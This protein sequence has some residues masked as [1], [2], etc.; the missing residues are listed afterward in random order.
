MFITVIVVLINNVFYTT[1]YA[2]IILELIALVAASIFYWLLIKGH[3]VRR[4]SSMLVIFLFVLIDIGTLTGS[5]LLVGNVVIYLLIVIVMNYLIPLRKKNLFGMLAFLNL[6]FLAILEY[7]LRPEITFDSYDS[8][9]IDKNILV[10]LGFGICYYLTGHMREKYEEERT[11]SLKQN[12]ELLEKNRKI[13]TQ[14]IEQRNLTAIIAHDLR[15][16]LNNIIGLSSILKESNTLSQKEEELVDR[17]TSI[18]DTGRELISEIVDMSNFEE[19][20]Y[21]LKL[22]P[23]KINQFVENQVNAYEGQLKEKNL[24]IDLKFGPKD[25]VVST[26]VHLLERIL[27]NLLSNAIKFSPEH[28]KI[29]IKIEVTSERFIVSVKDEGPGFTDVDKTLLYRKFQKLSARP[30]GD[31][32]STGLGLAIVK[33][34][35]ELLSGKIKLISEKGKGAE[36]VLE[37]PLAQTI[38]ISNQS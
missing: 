27:D 9:M 7:R 6:V 26:D 21:P 15:S 32:A 31:E 3:S 29:Q 28:K 10:F 11:L 1:V 37:F 33:A 30:T 2:L 34:L 4:L 23:V 25:S 13:E 18:A 24:E 38:K 36:F 16:P 12:E 19:A 17:M 22:E 35:M 14:N 5:G 20:D 8:Y